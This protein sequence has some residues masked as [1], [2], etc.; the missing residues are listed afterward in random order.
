MKRRDLLKAIARQ[1]KRRSVSWTLDR[2]G[3]NHDV[4]NLDGLMI[5]IARHSEIDDLF[6]VEIFKEC[7]P[8]LGKRWWK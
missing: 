2:N 3:A 6:A 8:K 7:E 5:P 1:A 4:Y